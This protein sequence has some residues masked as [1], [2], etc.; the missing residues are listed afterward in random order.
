MQYI[1]TTVTNI[2]DAKDSYYKFMRYII[3]KKI[4]G[5]SFNDDA[6]IIGMKALIKDIH[7]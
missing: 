4:N 7:F 2:I 5:K 1:D 6:P 3:K